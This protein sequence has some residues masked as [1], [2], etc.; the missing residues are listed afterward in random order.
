MN[1]QTPV[2][3]RQTST[4]QEKSHE[5]SAVWHLFFRSTVLQERSSEREK[6]AEPASIIIMDDD[7]DED[8]W[9]DHE[10]DLNELD[11]DEE[12][13]GSGE[14]HDSNNKNNSTK[15]SGD[16]FFGD[17]GQEEEEK[18]ESKGAVAAA[19]A[20]SSVAPQRPLPRRM[21]DETPVKETPPAEGWDDFDI[22][23]HHPNN[24]DHNIEEHVVSTTTTKDFSPIHGSSQP[25]SNGGGGGGGVPPNDHTI[26]TF[27][28]AVPM[29]ND[30]TVAG[31]TTPV[32]TNK[33]TSAAGGAD[34]DGWDDFGNDED[35]EDFFG[36]SKGRIDEDQVA[37]AT[38]PIV[39]PNNN[40]ASAPPTTRSTTTNETATI[41]RAPPIPVT[42]RLALELSDYILALPKHLHSIQMVLAAEY[43]TVE[44]AMEL[45]TYYR[46]RPALLQYTIE[47]EVSRLDYTV[48]YQGDVATDQAAVRQML[49]SAAAVAQD[50]HHGD[51]GAITICTR[52]ANQSLLADLLQVLTG[53]DRVVRPQYMA[54][55]VATT[56]RFHVDLD[57]GVVQAIATLEL[58]LPMSNGRWKIAEIQGMVVFEPEQRSVTF[59]VPD[60][61]L[62][63]HPEQQDE[64]AWHN[65]LH[66]S[67]SLLE[68]M[69]SAGG[70]DNDHDMQQ[71]Q[72][73]DA[74]QHQ[75]INFRDRFLQSQ[76]MLQASAAG[77]VQGMKSAWQDIDAATGF[78]NKLKHML[79]DTSALVQ[80][81]EE[82]ASAMAAPKHRPTSIL[83]GLVRS[84][85]KSVVLP[86]VVVDHD[87]EA[88]YYQAPPV[89]A[90]P[91]KLYNKV[92]V[93]A[94]QP[95]AAAAAAA[96][97]ASS[98]SVP[99]IPRLYNRDD[100]RSS[101]AHHV[102]DSIGKPYVA[103]TNN[104]PAIPQLYNRN[105]PVPR[106]AAAV[107]TVAMAPH[108]TTV[109]NQTDRPSLGTIRH[110]TTPSLTPQ[111]Y[112]STESMVIAD[113]DDNSNKNSA[114]AEDAWGDDLSVLDGDEN[115]QEEDD[116][117][118]DV[119]PG[120][121]GTK[122]N[123]TVAN[124]KRWVNPRLHACRSLVLLSK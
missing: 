101:T 122:R 59:R 48:V 91:P 18:K 45:T 4:Q 107:A 66:N 105:D 69:R 108:T 114:D 121:V 2:I 81:A 70:D 41:P 52:C 65:A 93:T 76:N 113:D 84:L 31:R 17:E 26:R 116:D 112:V 1:E 110:N 37:A 103:A 72:H 94:G 97:V 90:A 25:R 73:Y 67:A 54:T 28:S 88:E 63:T 14:H 46:S 32:T 7:E 111:Q 30:P 79:P 21:E 123:T 34:H 119:S 82:A 50:D 15:N 100:D 120:P 35:A 77:A 75:Q 5:I 80:Q 58:S 68:E 96:T 104:T 99:T 38:S 109:A 92:S 8:G 87:D 12:A 36:D 85:A 19:A 39:G 20:E 55:A 106:A 11:N 10:D 117:A 115:V 56:C 40:K 24:I 43:N 33:T 44:K 98:R 78:G 74:Q 86:D 124:R 3:H 95:V 22:S 16:D 62:L 64:M 53:S 83:G 49:A 23:D 47:K 57:A 27:L 89:A 71:Q 60:I 13:E 6:Q 118:V 61:R 29:K 9:G 102:T 51:S 42:S